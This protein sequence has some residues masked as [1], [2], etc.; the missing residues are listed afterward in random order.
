MAIIK[1]FFCRRV[2]GV[3]LLIT[4]MFLSLI[5]FML[6]YFLSLSLA[7]IK[8]SKSQTWGIKTYYLAEAGT[9]EMIWRLK[10]DA[11]YKNNFETNP[12]WTTSFARNN[13]FGVANESYEVSI[14]NSS[15][16]HGEIISTGK[17][18]LNNNK[19][20]Q[21]V[22]RT[23]VYKALGQSGV[24]D[25]AGYAD[26][27]ID[28]SASRVNFY[29]GSAHS[30]NT[31][32]LNNGSEIFVDSNLKATGNYIQSW[33][34][35]S[36]I[37]GTIRAANYPPAADP[38]DMPAIDFNSSA[39]SSYKNQASVV[40]TENQFDNLMKNNQNLTLNDPI[41]YVQGDVSVRGA[42]NLTINGLLVI[43]EDLEVGEDN[44]WQSRCGRSSITVNHAS[45][46]PA[47]ILAKAKINF[48]LYSGDIN[49][50][51]VVY[52]ND[53]LNILNIAAGL[54]SFNAVG[55]LVSR[56]LTITSSWEPINITHDS[57]ILVEVF[58]ATEFS[59][60]ILV[61][62]WEEEY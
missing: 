62:H 50:S 55:G 51:G 46:T 5:L 18:D 29:G 52:A 21:R 56:K 41:T 59:P 13:P 30:N 1:K 32:I 10:N 8:I 20:T 35:T 26:G 11:T 58:K 34:S 60:V 28:I 48:E 61:D 42:Q 44:C 57:D 3:A 43:E 40:Y 19:L 27:N 7:E 23:F 12:A 22:V 36:T 14:T 24:G 54:S 25:S 9:N 39:T 17:I 37:L 53:Q 45:G 33:T 15:E 16:A 31:F 2:K 38:I 47:G 49:I 4:M 6:L